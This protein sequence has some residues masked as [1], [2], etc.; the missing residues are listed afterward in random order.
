M[1][2]VTT[3]QP[4]YKLN[5]EIC[6][7]LAMADERKED[8]I[9]ATIDMY[10]NDELEVIRYSLSV[11]YTEVKHNGTTLLLIKISEHNR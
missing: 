6:D 7:N 10:T 8:Q 3:F 4:C 5:A 9:K 1:F 11:G 2:I